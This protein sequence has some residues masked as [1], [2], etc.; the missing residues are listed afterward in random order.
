M[1]ASE[2]ETQ[3]IVLRAQQGD[4]AS[5]AQLFERFSRRI[6][7]FLRLRVND[8]ATAEDLMQT[9]FLEMLRSLHHYQARSNA[10]FSTWLFQIARFRL[11]DH[12]RRQEHHQPLDEADEPV[13]PERTGTDSLAVDAV[14]GQLSERYQTVLHLRFREDLSVADTAKAMN[15]TAINVSV[16]QHRALKALRRL[17]TPPVT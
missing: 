15:I 6:Y 8:E 10:K 7:R 4:Q 5:M 1:E 13:A 12:Y 14:F 3:A 11:I 9:V 16:L 2:Q 17:M